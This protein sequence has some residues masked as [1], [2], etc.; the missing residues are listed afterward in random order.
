M[1]SYI[2][3]QDWFFSYYFTAG[4]AETTWEALREV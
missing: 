3:S 2:A 4:G 1:L